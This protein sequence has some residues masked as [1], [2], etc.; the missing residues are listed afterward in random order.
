MSSGRSRTVLPALLLVLLAIGGFRLFT[1]VIFTLDRDELAKRYSESFDKDVAEYPRFLA[2]VAS[3]TKRGDRIAIFVPARKWNDGYA[4]AYYRAHYFLTGREVLPLVWS[5]D[6]LLR[7]NFSA[8]Y[9]AV[10]RINYRPAG[11]R[12]V[13][14]SHEGVLL[15]RVSR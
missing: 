8:E 5:N 15:Q 9:L 14:A 3:W 10:W 13:G 11:Y 7:E 2:D 12:V 4:Y 6:R 1:V